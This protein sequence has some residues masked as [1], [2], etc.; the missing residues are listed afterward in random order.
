MLK[1]IIREVHLSGD[2]SLA[3]QRELLKRVTEFEWNRLLKTVKG[4]TDRVEGR[5]AQIV[6]EPGDVRFSV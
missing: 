2:A 4:T 3:A 6:L 5:F 1:S